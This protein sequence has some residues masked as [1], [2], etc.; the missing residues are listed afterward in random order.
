[1][2]LDIKGGSSWSSLLALVDLLNECID[3]LAR[4]NGHI[5]ILLQQEVV[6]L[7]EEVDIVLGGDQVS[8]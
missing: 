1:M 6:E 5:L 4:L 8:L 2:V 7:V 3:G